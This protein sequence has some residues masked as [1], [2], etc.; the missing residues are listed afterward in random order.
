MQLSNRFFA[1][2]QK[3]CTFSEPQPAPCLRKAFQ[4]DEIREASLSVCGLGLYELYINGKR[5]TRGRLGS[6][7]SN[8]DHILYYDTY[9]VSDYL[10]SGENVIALML[11]NGMLNCVGGGIWNFDQAVYRSAPKAALLFS[12]GELTFDASEFVWAPSPIIFDDLRAGEWY[13]A[14]LEIGKWMLPGYDDSAWSSVIAAETPRGLQRVNRTVPILPRGEIT[15]ISYYRGCISIFPDLE[16]RQPEL[17]FADD[18][19]DTEGWLYDFGVNTTGVC[20]LH[21]RNTKPGQKVILQYGEILGDNPAGA[22]DTT[23]RNENSGLDLRGFHFLP[24]RYN[25]RDVYI[26]RGD[27]EEIWEPVFTH[28]G[29]RYCLVIGLEDGQAAEDTL[30]AVV[31]HT[32]LEQRA[33]FR[34]SDET[35][36]RLWDAGILSDLGNFFHF[37]TDCPHREKN[38]WTGDAMNSA[39]QMLTVLSCEDNLSEWLLNLRCAM[40][41][42]GEL[43][44]VVPTTD[45]G[46]GIGPAHDGV[47]IEIPYQIWRL[48]GN[49]DVIRENAAAILRY[50]HYLSVRRNQKGLITFGLGDWCQA[51]RG[52]VDNPKAPSDFTS[53][54][55]CMQLSQKASRMFRAVSMDLEAD[56]AQALA[57]QLRDSARKHL[58]NLHTMTANYRCQTAQAMALYYDLFEPAERAAATEVLLQLIEENDGSFDCGVLGMRVIF[59]VLSRAGYTDRALHMITKKEFPSYGYWIANG[60]TTLWELFSPIERVQSSCNH[61]FFGDILSWF[62]Q[63]LAGIRQNPDA[64]DANSVIIEPHFPDLLSFAEGTIQI[65]AGT[66]ESHW[67]RTGDGVE[68]MVKIPKG[69]SAILRLDAGWQTDIGFTEYSLGKETTVK[70][71]KAGTRDRLR[72]TAKL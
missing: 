33:A 21:L 23:V 35:V 59:H 68:L 55:I 36:N 40:R 47:L 7:V 2:N 70:I 26:C 31:L 6:Y 57:S 18:E 3:Y 1:A 42:S 71:I 16:G 8:P 43:P 20:R 27:K 41:D 65:P 11:G 51:A 32:A 56:F 72:I 50:L 19:K 62:M 13:D 9:D 45:W 15:P 37:P 58:L 12:M 38:G 25:H 52:S 61:H 29:F 22:P 49:T 28:H 69:A 46:Y 5:I 67:K 14:R 10:Q 30:T 34:C 44:A 24:H 66:V 54:V 53:T 39:E 4:L 17:P 64:Q 60:A 63:N 48:R